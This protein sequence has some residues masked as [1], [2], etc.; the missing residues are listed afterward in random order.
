MKN[1]TEVRE[2]LSAVFEGLK[3]GD[4]KPN[5]ACE[6]N[7]ACGKIINSVKLELEYYSMIKETPKVRFL[8]I[9]DNS[10]K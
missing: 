2:A 3:N 5:V 7:N 9:E 10:E 4:I 8:Q 6:M 1:M